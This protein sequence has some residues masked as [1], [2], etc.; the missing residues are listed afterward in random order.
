MRCHYKDEL[1]AAT[2]LGEDSAG[3][4]GAREKLVALHPDLPDYGFPC[5]YSTSKPGSAT[6][7]AA[8]ASVRLEESS[9]K[10]NDTPFGFDWEH[11]RWPE[12]YRGALF[13]ALHGSYYSQPKWEGARIIFARTDP[14]NHMPIEGWR[15]FVG[16]FGCNKGEPCCDALSAAPPQCQQTGS[17]LDRPSDVAFAPDGRMFFADDQSGG[18]YWVAPASLRRPQN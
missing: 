14:S 12:P 13:V 1:C 9:F 16:G 11:D 3:A 7:A 18:V 15:D 8:C 10:L 2:E 6:T 4:F 5:C 17:I